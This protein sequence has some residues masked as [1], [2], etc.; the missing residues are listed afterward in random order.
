MYDLRKQD[1]Y[2]NEKKYEAYAFQRTVPNALQRNRI[3]NAWSVMKLNYN[4]I[5]HH[6]G[7]ATGM[8]RHFF[9][10]ISAFLFHICWW[11]STHFFPVF[12]AV[13]K[14]EIWTIIDSILWIKPASKRRCIWAF[15]WECL[16]F[17]LNMPLL[18]R[19]LVL[20]RMCFF[21]RDSE[22]SQPIHYG[23]WIT[24][25]KFRNFFEVGIRMR[26]QILND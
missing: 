12:P 22:F 6:A 21:S 1:M 14:T 7:S 19:R 17:F 10:S 9:Y 26:F 23:R 25:E 15:L 4:L 24:A 11:C 16:W 8:F 18:D 5:Y 13:P 2:C 3:E 20:C